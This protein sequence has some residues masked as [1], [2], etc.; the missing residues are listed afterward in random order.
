MEGLMVKH[1]NYGVR[2]ALCNGLDPEMVYGHNWRMLA[3]KL[4]YTYEEIMVCCL[5]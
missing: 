4:G 5:L 3:E 2:K 1:L